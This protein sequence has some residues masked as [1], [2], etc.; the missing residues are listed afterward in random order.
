MKNLHVKKVLASR[1]QL[2]VDQKSEGV[3]VSF[4]RFMVA[5]KEEIDIVSFA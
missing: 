3:Q 4:M 1:T 2:K 5:E